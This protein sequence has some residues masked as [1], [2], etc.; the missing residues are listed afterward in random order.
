MPLARR[1][2][3]SMAAATTPR[4][5]PL[6]TWAVARPRATHQ[7]PITHN[8]KPGNRADPIAEPHRVGLGRGRLGRPGER[9]QHHQHQHGQH[10]DR[11]RCDENTT[12]S[13]LHR[14]SFHRVAGLTDSRSGPARPRCPLDSAASDDY[15][16]GPKSVKTKLYASCSGS[17]SA[18]KAAG[19][20]AAIPGIS[21]MGKSNDFL[22]ISSARVSMGSMKM[23]LP[24]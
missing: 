6:I 1:M 8:T 23:G 17:Y 15:A 4:A 19:T 13:D 10:F 3:T 5:N 7:P 9:H 21:G 22:S 12:N 18:R 14:V 11:D 20:A 2:A 24:W 16:P